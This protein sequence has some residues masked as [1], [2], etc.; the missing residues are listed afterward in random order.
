MNPK[1]PCRASDGPLRGGRIHSIDD[2]TLPGATAGQ[3]I[4]A[5]SIGIGQQ[6]PP[7]FR[8]NMHR[9]AR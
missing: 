3:G 5:L 8:D 4:R 1:G 7:D 6:T 2:G 9:G